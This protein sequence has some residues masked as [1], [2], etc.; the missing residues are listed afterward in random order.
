MKLL[1]ILS[2]RDESN[3]TLKSQYDMLANQVSADTKEED[4][5]EAI[6]KYYNK[7]NRLNKSM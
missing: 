7:S 5:V 6:N 4:Y 2:K 3:M 1:D